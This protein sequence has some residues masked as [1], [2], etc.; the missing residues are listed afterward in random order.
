MGLEDGQLVD[1]RISNG[2]RD[3]VFDRTL[4]RVQP[5]AFTEMHIDTDEANA[6]GL[7]AGGAGDLVPQS[8]TLRVAD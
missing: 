2:V 7:G 5:G 4:I 6:A 8:A 3:L 1:V